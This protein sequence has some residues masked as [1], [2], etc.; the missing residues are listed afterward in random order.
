[1]QLSKCSLVPT[2]TRSPK[3]GQVLIFVPLFLWG[4]CPFFKNRTSPTFWGGPHSTFAVGPNSVPDL[5]Q[6]CR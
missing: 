4:T 6:G 5:G 3:L 1:M 2:N